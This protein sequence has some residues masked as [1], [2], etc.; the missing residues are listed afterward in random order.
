DIL[1]LGVPFSDPIADGPVLQRSA[2]RALSAGVTLDSVFGMAR[3]IREQTR[4]ALVL[5][6]Y[7]NPL[8]S[9]GEAAAREA[10]EAG[11]DG[12]LLTDL[13]PD[14]AAPYLP[15]WRDSQLDTIFL[16]SPTSTRERLAAAARVSTGFVSV[17]SRA[18]T[19][20]ARQNLPKD[21]PPT[22]RRA[23]TASK[24]LPLAIGFGISTAEAASRAASLADGVVVGSALVGAAEAAEDRRVEAVEDLAMVLSVACRRL[25]K[26]SS[27]P[28]CISS[29]IFLLTTHTPR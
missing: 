15:A 22:V 6:S 1:E 23:R 4:L 27:C 9:R 25:L 16:A 21:L 10:R 2:A 12:V 18:G 17:A 19:P 3:K 5:F 13:P 14:E 11:F 24:G 26:M 28:F 7:L 20:G 29:P 8:L